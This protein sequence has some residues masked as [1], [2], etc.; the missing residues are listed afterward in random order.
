MNGTIGEIRGFAGNFA[1][2]AWAFCEGQLLAISQN[3][4]LFSILG[5]TYG[6]D[7]RTSFALPDLRGR[8]PIS[9]GTGPGLRTWKLGARTGLEE[10]N[11]NVLQLAFHNHSA[12][13][14]TLSG[15]GAITGSAS[16]SINVNDG[17][18]S[19]TTP[20]GN[21][22]G[23]DNN[24]GGMYEQAGDGTSALNAGAVSVDTSNM[25]VALTNFSGG[26]TVAPSGSSQ[27]IN[28]M[29]P[30]LTVNWIVCMFGTYPSRS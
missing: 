6:G 28:N 15:T 29:M 1:P 9:A 10:N 22:I 5:T 2:R 20:N 3:T 16:A 27:G 23:V 17:D 11:L 4:A 18:G 26:V 8:V 12:S 30:V 21:Y 13:V 14:G 25:N 19:E 7:G 24:A